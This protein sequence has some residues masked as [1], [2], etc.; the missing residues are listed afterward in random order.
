MDIMFICY[1][2]QEMGRVVNSAEAKAIPI[3]CYNML[4]AK[5]H[6]ER[7][8]KLEAFLAVGGHKFQVPWE[9]AT[10]E[11]REQCSQPGSP[12]VLG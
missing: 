9:E 2:M 12:S 6:L 4:L 8:G 11:Q 3:G 7:N 10:E 5:M 1:K